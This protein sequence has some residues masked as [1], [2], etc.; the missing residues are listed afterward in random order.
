[1][2]DEKAG[3][4]CGCIELENL[5]I[6]S[7]VL[8]C[9]RRH[10]LLQKFIPIK[11]IGFKFQSIKDLYKAYGKEEPVD[12]GGVHSC[13]LIYKNLLKLSRPGK[14]LKNRY[15]PIWFEIDRLIKTG[16]QNFY[17]ID[18]VEKLHDKIRCHIKLRSP[19]RN[20]FLEELLSNDNIEANHLILPRKHFSWAF[21]D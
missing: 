4:S 8:F 6:V 21:L 9:H 5:A 15:K 19:K 17:A 11:N 3:E 7:I 2:C 10:I 14:N 18:K 13:T 20:V 1:M 12:V 16:L